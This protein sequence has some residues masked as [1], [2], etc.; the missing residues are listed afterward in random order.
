MRSIQETTWNG[1]L[2]WLGRHLTQGFLLWEFQ[3]CISWSHLTHFGAHCKTYVHSG[4]FMSHFHILWYEWRFK[5]HYISAF[6]STIF[7]EKDTPR[8]FM[9]GRYQKVVAAKYARSKNDP[10]AFMLFRYLAVLFLERVQDF[11][12][13]LIKMGTARPKIPYHNGKCKT[14]SSYIRLVNDDR[15]PLEWRQGRP[16]HWSWGI[17]QPKCTWKPEREG[18]NGK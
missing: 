14:W 9:M 5:R 13:R 1:T 16:W 7:G 8:K 10:L 3:W 4:A 12:L 15:K 2:K 6:Y 17:E 18:Y 11:N